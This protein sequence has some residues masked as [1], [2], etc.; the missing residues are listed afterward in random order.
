MKFTQ[1]LKGKKLTHA[2]TCRNLEDAMLGEISQTQKE[3]HYISLF[4]PRIHCDKK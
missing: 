2:T 1:P 4:I 3:K